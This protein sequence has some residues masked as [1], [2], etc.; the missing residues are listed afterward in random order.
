MNLKLE[1]YHTNKQHNLVVSNNIRVEFTLT[2]LFYSVKK[3]MRFYLCLIIKKSIS[4]ILI[5][6][7]N[8]TRIAISIF[9]FSFINYY[10]SLCEIKSHSINVPVNRFHDMICLPQLIINRAG[11]NFVKLFS[12]N[13]K[14]P[15][16]TS[17]NKEKVY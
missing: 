16:V 5:L 4:F 7:N 17:Q 10:P 9:F 14:A 12:K 8:F 11:C 15:R 3:I 6:L 2:L 1:F 13:I